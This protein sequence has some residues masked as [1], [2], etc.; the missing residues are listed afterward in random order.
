M[1]KADALLGLGRM[2]EA[3]QT[4]DQARA[5]DPWDMRV[6]TFDQIKALV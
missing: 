4:M 5:I 3:E 6:Y 1:L 2:Q